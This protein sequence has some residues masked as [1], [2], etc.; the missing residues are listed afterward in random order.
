MKY[1][2]YLTLLLFISCKTKISENFND[3]TL[4]PVKEQLNKN[5]YKY[6]QGIKDGD[7]ILDL[8][9]YSNVP[10]SKTNPEMPINCFGLFNSAKDLQYFVEEMDGQYVLY[11]EKEGKVI[12]REYGNY[13]DFN[14]LRDTDS[15]KWLTTKITTEKQVYD[16]LH[17]NNIKYKL[18]SKKS[19][20]TETEIKI[21]LEPSGYYTYISFDGYHYL[22]SNTYY[23]PKD[24]IFNYKKLG[25][26][27]FR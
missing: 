13:F 27:L 8:L 18:I 12:M 19:S 22:V 26:S 6:T 1:T 10:K 20:R 2:L 7:K 25:Y 15:L 5:Y 11:L 17:K 4:K 16:L 21:Q 14:K 3:I 9:I 24:T 23:E